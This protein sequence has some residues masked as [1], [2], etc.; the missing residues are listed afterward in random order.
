MRPTFIEIDI[1]ALK[2]NMAYV[3]ACCPSQKVVA[4]VKAN[5]YGCG[6]QAIVPEIST[7]VDAF[8]V[9]CLEE[10]MALRSLT[11]KPCVLFQGVFSSGELF[12]VSALDLD[13]VIHHR[14]QLEWLLAT[15][16]AK[17]IRVWLK[18]N[19]GMNRLG[20][21]PNE[22]LD[23]FRAL[24]NCPWVS[25]DITVLSHM[26]CADEPSNPQNQAQMTRFDELTST[27]EGVS[28]S[29][30][31]SAV[32]LTAPNLHYDWVRPGIMIYGVS[33]LQ[34]KMATALNLHP[35][36]Q[37][38][39]T[40]TVIHDVS[41]Y[42]PIGY[43]GTWKTKKAARIG[44]VAAG[45]GDGY[46]RHIE[47]GTAVWLKGHRVPIVGRVSMDM[48]TVDLSAVPDACVGDR[49]ELWGKH[50]LVEEVALRA[51]TS[52]YE[53]LCQVSSRA[54]EKLRFMK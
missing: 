6:I 8:G 18:V 49:V 26:A 51:G 39:S 54:R 40:I 47:E 38:I 25:N 30:A 24:K 37:F 22:F 43:G 29:F 50:I 36:M 44:V 20:V 12:D 21:E 16:L 14:L 52:A 45:Y 2:H 31:N 10:A 11:S 5:A 15:P 4:M 23:I 48:M 53:L 33:P 7:K 41:A 35:V 1:R 17:P 46:P 13:C 28:R 3:R 27:L 32:I 42:Q 9:A 19:T 34:D